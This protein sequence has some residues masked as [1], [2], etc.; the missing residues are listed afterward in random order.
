MGEI[1]RTPGVRARAQRRIEELMAE[2]AEARTIADALAAHADEHYRR[3]TNA[4]AQA[5]HYRQALAEEPS[6]G[7]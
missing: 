4:E 2:A 1:D 5:S 7:R 3:A 6:D